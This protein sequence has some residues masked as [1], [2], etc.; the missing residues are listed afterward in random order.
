MAASAA[1]ISYTVSTGPSPTELNT[2][3]NVPQF[4]LLGQTLQSVQWTLSGTVSGTVTLTNNSGT[5]QTLSATSSSQ[6][7]GTDTV[8]TGQ[9]VFTAQWTTGSVTIPAGQTQSFTGSGSNSQTSAVF[10]ALAGYIGAGTWSETLTTLSGL[11]LLGGGG[12]IAN[13]QA[14]LASGILTVTYTYSDVVPEPATFFL[15]GGALI[16]VA[17]I[18]RRRKS[19]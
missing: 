12:Q 7:T 19:A 18:L 2:A 9:V 4:N 13:T 15:S 8:S 14:L 10:G 16:A 11:S 5:S 6:F 17:S 3:L 1:T